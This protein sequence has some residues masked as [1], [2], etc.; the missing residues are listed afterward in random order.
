MAF[1]R[2]VRDG[3]CASMPPRFGRWRMARGCAPPCAKPNKLRDI[4]SSGDEGTVRGRCKVPFHD[5]A[6]SLVQSPPWKRPLLPLLLPSVDA[7][8]SLDNTG[9][10][11]ASVELDSRRT[12][13]PLRFPPIECA[14]V[15]SLSLRSPP[16]VPLAPCVESVSASEEGALAS[17][18]AKEPE[19]PFESISLKSWTVLD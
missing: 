18:N 4:D 15:L 10:A 2:T 6:L 1:A 19:L 3:G 14:R 16:L 11:S 13:A 12:P 7:V 8:P 9:S 5:G 17:K